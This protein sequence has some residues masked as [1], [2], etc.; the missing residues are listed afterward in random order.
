MN[1]L[2][3]P[4]AADRLRLTPATVRRMANRG[5]LSASLIGRQWRIPEDSI[6][7]LVARH[8]NRERRSPRRRRNRTT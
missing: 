4:E 7:D 8:S 6:D 3:V 1:L 5:E 2:T